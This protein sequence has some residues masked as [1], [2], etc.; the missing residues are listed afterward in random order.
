MIP[1]RVRV[2]EQATSRLKYLKSKTG[3]TPNILSRFAF[4]L[5]A[6]DL[7]RVTRA[8]SDLAG[9][10]FLAPTLFGEHQEMYDLILVRYAE[11]TED[12]REP[13]AIIAHHIESGLHR[14]AHVRG[15]DDLVALK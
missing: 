1:Y 13:A 15:L 14:M 9:Q 6:R 12:D 11:Q 8:T 2:S 3:L 5:S 10:E 7:R 4:L